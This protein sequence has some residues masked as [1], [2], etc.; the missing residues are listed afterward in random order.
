MK[1]NKTPREVAEEILINLT[2]RHRELNSHVYFEAL[3]DASDKIAE[4]IQAERQAARADLLKA[5][6]DDSEIE[7]FGVNRK[8][9]YA[10]FGEESRWPDF[11]EGA[12]WLRNRLQER[13]KGDG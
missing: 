5:L 10:A 7:H 2:N 4:A 8:K 9:V 1:L 12:K 6:H 11:A 3:Q 13:I